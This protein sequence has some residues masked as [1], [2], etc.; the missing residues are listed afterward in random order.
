MPYLLIPQTLVRRERWPGGNWLQASPLVMPG[1]HVLPDQPVMRLARASQITTDKGPFPVNTT[2]SGP[3]SIA[4]PQR[5]LETIPAG[6][7]GRVVGLT[8]RGGVVLEARA[9]LLSGAI[10]AGRQVAGILT[11]WHA[12]QTLRKQR[13]IPPGAILVVNGSVD[14]TLLSQAQRSEVAGIVAGSISLPDFEGVIRT[15]LIQ[16]ISSVDVE[17]AQAYLPP[18]TLL[19]TEGVGS[20]AMPE[21]VFTLLNEHQGSIAL[22]AGATSVPLGLYPE[23]IISLPQ[24]TMQVSQAVQATPLLVPGALVRVCG[25]DHQGALGVIDHL[26]AYQYTFPSGVRSRAARLFLED[27]RRI[28][29]PLFLVERIG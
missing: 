13:V 18:L 25:G 28:I 3:L 6:V 12:D 23:L 4:D 10:G 21:H 22:L 19:F 14:L 9:T 27:G 29:V 2:C 16:L 24:E 17:R 8:P 11:I 5:V 15:D 1:Q 7:Y 26:F 20:L